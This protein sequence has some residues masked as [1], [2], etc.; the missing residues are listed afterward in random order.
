LREREFIEERTE[1]GERA[2]ELEE[3]TMSQPSFAEAMAEK[4]GAPV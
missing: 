1:E 2:V 4:Y 3:L